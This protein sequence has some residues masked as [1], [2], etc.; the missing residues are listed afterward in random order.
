M[1]VLEARFYPRRKTQPDFVLICYLVWGGH[2]LCKQPVVQPATS[3]LSGPLISKLRYLLN[4][5]KPDCFERLQSLRSD[6]WSFV[7][8]TGSR[9]AA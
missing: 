1:R 6:F 4:L 5:T 2:H 3:S 9:K 8:V 7:D